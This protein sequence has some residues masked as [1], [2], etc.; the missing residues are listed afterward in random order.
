M[1]VFVRLFCHLTNVEKWKHNK[2]NSFVQW[3]Q[4]N[5]DDDNDFGAHTHTHTLTNDTKWAIFVKFEIFHLFWYHF[6]HVGEHSTLHNNRFNLWSRII[7][8]HRNDSIHQFAIFGFLALISIFRVLLFWCWR[9][10]IQWHKIL[11]VCAGLFECIR[12]QFEKFE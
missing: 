1:R 5:D 4:Q 11:H 3:H 8:P 7:K 12:R 2:I 9:I 6:G 10:T